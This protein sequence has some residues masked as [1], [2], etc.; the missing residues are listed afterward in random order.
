M[1]RTLRVAGAVLALTVSTVPAG[2]TGAVPNAATAC[3][4]TTSDGDCWPKSQW[5]C[6]V[7]LIMM[8]HYCDRDLVP[9]FCPFG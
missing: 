7:G 5:V 9:Q 6:F 8:D 2:A 4:T 1:R 3:R